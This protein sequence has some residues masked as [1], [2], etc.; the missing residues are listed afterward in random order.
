MSPQR[1]LLLWPP[2]ITI[3]DPN[4]LRMLIIRTSCC[5]H[6]S[7]PNRLDLSD[8]RPPLCPSTVLVDV[9]RSV[10]WPTQIKLISRQSGLEMTTRADAN[11]PRLAAIIYYPSYLSLIDRT[12][13]WSVSLIGAFRNNW[14]L[15]IIY[16][17]NSDVGRRTCRRCGRAVGRLTNGAPVCMQSLTE[18]RSELRLRFWQHVEIE[19]DNWSKSWL[20]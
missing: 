6:S 3:Y 5:R 18:C 9:R 19:F 1:T 2:C 4:L 10:A 13:G 17:E 8:M 16:W 7:V 20:R 15:S 14:F 12:T 11:D